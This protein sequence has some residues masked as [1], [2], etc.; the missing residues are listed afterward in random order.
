MPEGLLL[1]VSSSVGL[2]VGLV[3]GPRVFTL[4]LVG[5]GQSFGELG[6]VEEIGPTDNSGL[7]LGVRGYCLGLWL[8]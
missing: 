4:R 2:W 5:L 8:G 6:W 7:E 1:V 3:C